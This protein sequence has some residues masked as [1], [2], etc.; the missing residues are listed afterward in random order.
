M[1]R[2]RAEAERS[3]RSATEDRNKQHSF[4]NLFSMTCPKSGCGYEMSVQSRDSSTDSN[5]KPIERVKY[6]CSYDKTR[7]VAEIPKDEEASS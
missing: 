2:A 7:V 5:G 6:T 3:I 1:I 4:N